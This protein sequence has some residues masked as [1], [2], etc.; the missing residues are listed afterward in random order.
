MAE[1]ALVR[2]RRSLL[3]VALGLALISCQA[4]PARDASGD[5][6][7]QGE[8][9]VFRFR[10]GDCFND[11]SSGL[12][13]VTDVEAVPCSQA[14]DNEV[15]HLFDLP[16]GSY[17]DSATIDQHVLE[18]CLPAFETYVGTPYEISELYVVP[19]TPT[20][21]SWAAADREVVCALYADGARLMGT[22]KGARR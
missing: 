9:S 4:E 3:V 6:A 1:F 16:D 11:P 18:E 7:E 17:P 5:I 10:V 20:E 21:E 12:E 15:F 22:M 13:V 8:L 2:N 19:I 14:H